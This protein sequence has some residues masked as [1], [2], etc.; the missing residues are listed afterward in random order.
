MARV[1]DTVGSMTHAT[2]DSGEMFT[3]PGTAVGT[4]AYMSPEQLRGK[5]L[6]SRSDLFSFGTVL[7]EMATG[8]LPFAG[9]TTGVI[10]EA[11]LNRAPPP[12]VRLKPDLPSK[13]DDIV[14]KALEKDRE[15]RY[16]VAAEMRADLKRLRRETDS[17]GRVVTAEGSSRISAGAA[18]PPSGTTTVPACSPSAATR[19]TV[20]QVAGRH[21]MGIAV[22][23]LV[24]LALVAAAAFGVYSLLSR[25]KPEAFGQF[26]VSR[27]TET[28][29]AALAA[30]SPDGNYILNAQVENGQ[31]SLWLRNIPTN[32]N[33][34]IIP[35][36]DDLYRG[37]QFSP[38]GNF[39]YFVKAE[40]NEKDVNSLYRIPVLG[41]SPSRI[42]QHIDSNISFSPDRRR[43][44]FVRN[45]PNEGESDVLI[46]NSDGSGETLL[47][48][49]TIHLFDPAWSPDGKL[50]QLLN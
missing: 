28:R 15:L 6:D 14:Q 37:L 44:V 32:S 48:K 25:K 9:E 43:F 16:Q 3:S 41:G 26:S 18:S 13:L 33:T 31:Q 30:I 17:S 4:V 5:E 12:L 24:V 29:K 21:K 22:A 2:L 19:S 11:I 20:L 8:V 45:K 1:G 40:R 10:F 35:P 27:V 7:Y 46:A 38:D 49:Q 23:S 42:V 47:A 50:M 34:Q 36:S 39:I